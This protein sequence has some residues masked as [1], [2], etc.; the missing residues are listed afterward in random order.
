MSLNYWKKLAQVF[1]VFSGELV[2]RR[3]RHGAS[4]NTNVYNSSF[5]VWMNEFILSS[6][7]PFLLVPLGSLPVN[8]RYET[9]RR[10]PYQQADDNDSPYQIIL[11][12]A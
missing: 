2:G 3:Q 4:G 11:K 10:N 8:P 12:K 7:F 1:L 9:G 5:V 6:P